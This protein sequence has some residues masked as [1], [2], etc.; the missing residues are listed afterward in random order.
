[1]ICRGS[2]AIK[3]KAWKEGRGKVWQ[4]NA[5]INLVLL[6]NFSAIARIKEQE[7]LPYD[8]PLFA[9][10]GYHDILGIKF[11]YKLERS[12]LSSAISR[13]KPTVQTSSDRKLW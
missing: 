12:D 6:P 13:K 7:K 2:P 11:A 5:A 9:T 1:M 10:V 3:P 8:G 4:Q